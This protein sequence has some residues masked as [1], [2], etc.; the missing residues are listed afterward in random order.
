MRIVQYRAKG[1]IDPNVAAAMRGATRRA[2]AL[3]LLNDRWQDVERYDADGAHVGPEDAAPQEIAAIRA[4][5]TGKILG[6]SCGTPGEARAAAA[7]GADYVGAGCLFA[8]NS[9]ADAGEPIGLTGLRAIVESTPLPVAAIGGITRSQ[10]QAVR[11]AGATM[12]AVI[13]AIAGAADPR[14]AARELVQAWNAV[15]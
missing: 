7:A 4:A 10:I 2:G 8:T 5:L 3:W 1:G 12:A 15:R 9:K 14:A 13:S 6:I 11:Q